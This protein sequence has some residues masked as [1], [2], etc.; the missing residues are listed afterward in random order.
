MRS[1]LVSASSAAPAVSGDPQ[2]VHI[3]GVSVRGKMSGGTE[4]TIPDED[5]GITCANGRW[6]CRMRRG[7]EATPYKR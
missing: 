7:F 6:R 3:V 2:T 4:G 1:L 5:L